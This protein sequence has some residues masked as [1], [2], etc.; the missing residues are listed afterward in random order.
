MAEKK[1]TKIASWGKWSPKSYLNDYFSSLTPDEAATLNFI[2]EIP[3][4]GL[5]GSTVLEI[6]CGPMTI[7]SIAIAPYVS[8][9]HMADYLTENLKE[10]S[11]WQKKSPGAFSWK[12]FTRHILKKEG[13]K[14]LKKSIEKRED[15]A[16]KKIARLLFCD[17]KK[18]HPIPSSPEKKYPLVLSLFCAD[19]IT[20]SHATWRRCIKNL[21]GLVEKNGGVCIAAL[22]NSKSYKIGNQLFPAANVNEQHLKNALVDNGVNPETLI[23]RVVKVPSCSSHGFRSIMFAYGRKR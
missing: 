15:L 8:K 13:Q 1:P 19:S 22:R 9:I 10:V 20:S 21:I 4:D 12:N 18:N 7:H 6:G 3:K 14:I 17:L 16:R 2:N 5:R 11:L 23:I